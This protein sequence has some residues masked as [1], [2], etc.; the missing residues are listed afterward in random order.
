MSKQGESNDWQ[1]DGLGKL[2]RQAHQEEPNAETDRAI[3]AA[4]HAHRARRSRPL[5]WAVP[6]ATAASLILAV[7]L[8][9]FTYDGHDPMQLSHQKDQT[10]VPAQTVIRQFAE[11]KAA[12]P[13]FKEEKASPKREASERLAMA[14]KQRKQSAEMESAR[15]ETERMD[16]AQPEAAALAKQPRRD[17]ATLPEPMAMLSIPASAGAA[18]NKAIKHYFQQHLAAGYQVVAGAQALAADM[19]GD[20]QP[21][22]AGLV[23]DKQRRIDLL[24]IVSQQ[25]RHVHQVLEQGLV[26]EN[27]L[28]GVR[29]QQAI[30]TATQAAVGSSALQVTVP[31]R[32]S[33]VYYWDGQRFKK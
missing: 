17:T 26:K 4:A 28:A 24:V 23:M 16:R 21:D 22:W 1:H 20:G 3:L 25:G 18:M 32:E 29:L 33:R 31:G 5:R 15:M 2:Y 19:N 14:D 8:L 9:W 13:A 30:T 11:E 6:L 27:Q 7:N 10:N 12:A